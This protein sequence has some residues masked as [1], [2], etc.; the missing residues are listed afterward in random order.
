MTEKK[1]KSTNQPLHVRVI[2][3]RNQMI[4]LVADTKETIKHFK[5]RLPVWHLGGVSTSN[6]VRLLCEGQ[7]LADVGM[8]ADGMWG[9]FSLGDCHVKDRAIVLF[10]PLPPLVISEATTTTSSNFN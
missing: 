3:E 4:E 10:A 7:K 9:D 5:S 2:V 6:D 8:K 1:Q